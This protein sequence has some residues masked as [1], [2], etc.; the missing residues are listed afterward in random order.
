MVSI[1]SLGPVGDRRKNPATAAIT[2]KTATIIAH[3]VLLFGMF[4][5]LIPHA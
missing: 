5:H 3:I 4:H 2:T 1:T